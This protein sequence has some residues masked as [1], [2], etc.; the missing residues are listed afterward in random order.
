MKTLNIPKSKIEMAKFYGC[1]VEQLEKQLTSNLAGINKLRN[2]AKL[3]GKKVNG[4]TESQLNDYSN[5][6]NQ[7]LK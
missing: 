1:S 7:L 3:R 5:K 6:Y 2:K 4:F